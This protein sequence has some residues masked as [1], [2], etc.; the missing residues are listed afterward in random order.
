MLSVWFQIVSI[1]GLL[2]SVFITLFFWLLEY[3]GNYCLKLPQASHMLIL[4]YS[5]H[6]F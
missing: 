3:E 2:I 6:C 4:H 1:V 5:K